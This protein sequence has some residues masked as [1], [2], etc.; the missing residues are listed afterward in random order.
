MEIQ[1]IHGEFNS[2]EAVD[3]ISQ[4]IHL[5]VKFHENKITNQSSEEEIKY[6][7][8]KIKDLQKQILSLREH[9]KT[10]EN[11]VSIDATIKIDKP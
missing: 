10:S 3:L 9:L 5:K 6:G 2:K 7:E 11:N 4:M 8:A 1:L